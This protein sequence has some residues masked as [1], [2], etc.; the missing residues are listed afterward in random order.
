MPGWSG[1]L[2][3]LLIFAVI[4]YT[5][6]NLFAWLFYGLFEYYA[7]GALGIFLAAVVANGV[8]V[9]IFERGRLDDVG[10]SWNPGS[11]R[12]LILGLL[13]GICAALAV[14]GS[15]LLFRFAALTPSPD[16]IH[17]WGFGKFILVT[18]LLVFGAVGEELFFHGYGFQLLVARL[19]PWQTIL[20]FSVLFAFAHSTNP[21]SNWLGLVNTGAWGLVLGYALLRTRDLWLAIGLHF[22]WNWILPLFG[23]NLSG[24][25]MGLLGYELRWTSSSPW[26][27]AGYGPEGSLLTSIIVI[28]VLGWLYRVRIIPQPGTLLARL[29]QREPQ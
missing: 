1:V 22:G 20:P 4:A 13:G 19:G 17:A 24:F 3:R 14:I 26:S 28:I 10:M 23:A 15:A 18:V 9:R 5:G 12:H 6:L 16:S 25:R 2:L 27:G 11:V 8:V 29:N 21:N 7:A